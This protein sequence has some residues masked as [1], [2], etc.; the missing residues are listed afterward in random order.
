MNFVD[1]SC[2]KSIS[3][4]PCWY[5]V[6][7]NTPIKTLK[8]IGPPKYPAHIHILQSIENISVLYDLGVTIRYVEDED[9]VVYNGEAENLKARAKHIYEKIKLKGKMRF[10]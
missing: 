3:A 4:E 6:T 9:W 1:N 7:T 8:S 5:L 10:L 2:R